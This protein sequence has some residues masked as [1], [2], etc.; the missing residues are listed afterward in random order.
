MG[1][2]GWL[3]TYAV[4]GC[5]DGSRVG[6]LTLRDAAVGTVCEAVGFVT[7]TEQVLLVEGVVLGVVV[8]LDV[9]V[10]VVDVVE[11]EVVLEDDVVVDV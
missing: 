4:V 8:V 7:Q 2:A 9:V 5:D 11:D 1:D 6:T 3:G 10:V